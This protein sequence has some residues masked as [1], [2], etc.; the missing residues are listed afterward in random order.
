MN[1]RYNGVIFHITSLP[2]P[3]G[4]GTFSDEAEEVAELLHKGDVSYWQVLPFTPPSAGDSPYTSYSA[5]AGCTWFIDPRRT[6]L[7]TKEEC[8]QFRYEGPPY[9]VDYDFVRQNSEAYLRLAFSRLTPDQLEE[10]RSFSAREPWLPEYA[11]FMA[12]REHYDDLP[13]YE[14]PDDKLRMHDREA[15]LAFAEEHREELDF[16]YFCQWEFRRQWIQLKRHINGLGIGIIGD[17][18]MYVAHDSSDA[19]A[20]PK[21]YQFDEENNPLAVAGVPPDYFS[22]DGQLWGNPLY[23]WGYHKK[24]EYE[25]WIERL[26]QCFFL[27]DAVRIDHFRAFDSYWA[28][29]A[30][31]ETAKEGRWEQG[32]GMDLIEAINTAIPDAHI[33]AEDLGIVTEGVVELLDQSGYPGMMV[34]QF[35]LGSFE[36]GQRMPHRS[37]ENQAIYTGTHDNNTVLGWASE[38][39]YFHRQQMLDYI[40]FPENEDWTVGGL[41]APLNRAFIR[42]TWAAPAYLAVTTIQD[43]LGYGADTRMNIPGTKEGN[44][45]FRVPLDALQR[46]DWDWLAYMNLLFDRAYPYD[47]MDAIELS[48]HADEAVDPDTL[49]EEAAMASEEGSGE[50]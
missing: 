29:P 48:I 10:V 22:E 20:N 33:I 9:E 21:L 37:H 28:V 12:I 25:W 23:D 14:W 36:P 50:D 17:V 15:L 18:P 47:E 4:I 32:P 16:T 24:T 41:H 31:S 45:T 35:A 30:G 43:L 44:W 13:W 39:E 38:D 19:W 8:E 11:M 34:M 6:H 46:S 26:K 7:L 27:Y 3:Y 1:K 40:G 42:Q 2:G 49:P 5:F